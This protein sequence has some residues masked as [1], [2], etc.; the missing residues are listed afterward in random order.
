MLKKGADREKVLALLEAEGTCSEAAVRAVARETGVPEAEVWGAAS[1]YALLRDRDI[2]RRVCKGLT[3]RLAGSERIL[4]EGIGSAAT[5]HGVSCL[6]QCDRAPVWLDEELRLSSGNDAAAAAATDDPCLPI[7]LGGAS[8]RDLEYKALA[9]ARSLGPEA[10]LRE[11]E[12]SGLQGRG[13]AGFLAHTKWAS[14]RAQPAAERYLVCN[15]D[16]GA[17]G[18]FK[19]REILLQRP[20]R[21]VEG[22]AICAEVVGA[23][24]VYLYVR[25]EFLAERASLARALEAAA[26]A[27]DGIDVHVVSGH[28]A[29]ICGEETAL[30]ESLEGKRGVPRVKPPFPTEVGFRG[31]PTLIHNVETLA[32]VPA[33]VERGGAWFRELGRGEA[34]TKLYC[35][36]GHVRSAGVHELP[37]GV[38]L[39]ELVE[40]AGGYVGS[41]LSFSP[42]GASSGFLPMSDRERPLDF[43]HLAAV[44]SLLGSA[45]VRAGSAPATCGVS[46]T[47]TC[48]TATRWRCSASTTWPGRWNRRRSAGSG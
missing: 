36:S 27:F 13:G 8:S 22:A 5:T 45:G 3:C 20:H 19:D 6:G 4:A 30:L 43:G 37:L 14:V 29:Y 42:G 24:S 47:S 34:G 39:D 38:T 25:G 35:V 9:R 7:N 2:S 1:F 48:S 32:C 17:P 11:L 15:A 16:E 41:P 12:D 40:A 23:R 10:V 33:I 28:G 31:K 18:T 26:G 44:G 46:S 21:L